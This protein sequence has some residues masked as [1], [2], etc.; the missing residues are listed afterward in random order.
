VLSP[1]QRRAKAKR[2]KMIASIGY[3]FKN[4]MDYAWPPPVAVPR[5]R[6][7]RSTRVAGGKRRSGFKDDEATEA[8]GGDDEEEEEEEEAAAAPAPASRK[9]ARTGSGAKPTLAVPGEAAYA[10]LGGSP[11]GVT[12]PMVALTV[13]AAAAPRPGALIRQSE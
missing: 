5:P 13:G 10:S 11:T 6:R 7:P 12:Q 9:V 8:G 2:A 4:V 3:N 1:K